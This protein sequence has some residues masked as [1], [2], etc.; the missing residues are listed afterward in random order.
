MSNISDNMTPI[1]NVA[2]KPKFWL[3]WPVLLGPIAMISVYL[4][5]GLEFEGF[6]NK[7]IHETLAL[8]ILPLAIVSYGTGAAYGRRPIHLIL[9]VLTIALFCREWHFTGTSTGIYISLVAIGIW[10]Y[11]WREKIKPA[12]Q[13]RQ[14]RIWLISTCATYFLSVLIS[15]RLFKHLFLP[16]E[17]QLHV[18]L[19]EVTETAAHLMLLITSLIAWKLCRDW[20]I[21]N[22]NIEIRNKSK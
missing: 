1:P 11:L 5:K 17:K 20:K 16:M 9:T 18:P 10:T 13:Y 15:R 19:E 7:R 4:A 12:L 2:H 22:P 3:W 21:Q 8:I 6:Y 14:F